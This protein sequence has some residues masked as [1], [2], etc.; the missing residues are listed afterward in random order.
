MVKLRPS[1]ALDLPVA[2]QD[3]LRHAGMSF[4]HDSVESLQDALMQT[5]LERSRKLHDHYESAAAGAHDGLAEH[6]SRADAD[7]DVI[8]RA[9]YRHAPFQT[10]RLTNAKLDAQLRAMEAELEER[11]GELLEAEGSELTMDDG[12]VRAFVARYGR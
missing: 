5:Q 12:R 11:D 3:A 4:N 6:S 1:Q 7:Q 8:L 2:L 9:L 10:V